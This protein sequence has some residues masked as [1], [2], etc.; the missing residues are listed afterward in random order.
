M[1]ELNKQQQVSDEEL[2]AI[3]DQHIMESGQTGYL[4]FKRQTPDER[5]A[6]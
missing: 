2:F 3:I 1:A 6:L 5:V 4:P